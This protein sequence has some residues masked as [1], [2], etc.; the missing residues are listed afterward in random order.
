[1]KAIMV[2]AQCL[3]QV[4]VLLPSKIWGE[5]KFACKDMAYSR[6]VPVM[7]QLLILHHPTLIVVT[8]ALPNFSV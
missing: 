5:H 3:Y 7:K 4:Q 1:M 6:R 8:V 2:Q